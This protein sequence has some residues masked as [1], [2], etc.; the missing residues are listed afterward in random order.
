[1]WIVTSP[2]T[3]GTLRALTGAL[4]LLLC[5]WA[6]PPFSFL[7]TI[8]CTI[9]LLYAPSFI[10]VLSNVRVPIPDG[11]VRTASVRFQGWHRAWHCKVPLAPRQGSMDFLQA[12]SWSRSGCGQVS[13][14]KCDVAKCDTAWRS[15]GAPRGMPWR[16]AAVCGM[17]FLGGTR[18]F[19]W[20]VHSDACYSCSYSCSY[21]WCFCST[22]YNDLQAGTTE[23]VTVR[24]V[25]FMYELVDIVRT[26][27]HQR[28]HCCGLN[29][30]TYCVNQT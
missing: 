8:Y 4:F 28:G 14:R 24:G 18:L 1:M 3:V 23:G 21:C 17:E 6:S 15:I 19:L 22:R 16:G 20:H 26:L 13:V 25:K 9:I 2:S 11:I 7:C 29:H 10:R 5:V 30:L 27:E 12:V